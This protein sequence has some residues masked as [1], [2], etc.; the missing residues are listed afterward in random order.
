MPGNSCHN[1]LSW[2]QLLGHLIMADF[3]MKII[4]IHRN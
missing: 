3:A 2:H 1:M 4:E